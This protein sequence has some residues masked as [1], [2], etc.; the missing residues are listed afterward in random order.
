MKRLAVLVSGNGTNLQAIMDAV[1]SGRIVAAISAV[2]SDRKDAYAITRARNHGIPVHVR[3][4][5]K[6]NRDTYF[7]G[8]MDALEEASP[9]I[10]V[11][12]GFMKI[13]PD[14]F[15]DTFRNRMINVHP[16]LLP[17]FGGKGMYGSRVHEA[18]IESGSRFT[19]CTVHFVSSEVDG[20]PIIEQRIME[21][22]DDDTSETLAARLHPLEHEAMIS[23]I[24]LLLSGK[25]R[26]AGK[27]VIRS[28]AG[29]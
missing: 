28:Q 19:G 8:L 14:S 15:V 6:E 23:A 16:S 13:L 17:C 9:D 11:L 12:A 5:T 24:S 3:I 29:L 18:V 1:E 7:Q 21:V 4:R 2:I 10:V 27:R 25:Y 22:K 20:G 26:I